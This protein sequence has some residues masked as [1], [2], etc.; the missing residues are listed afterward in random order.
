M[1]VRPASW[2]LLDTS[3]LIAPPPRL[4]S[5]ARS[6]AVSTI[7]LAELAFGLH[8]P[9]PVVNAARE[10]RYRR[11]V[12]SVEP[13]AYSSSAARLYG[14]LC[15]AVH[16]DGR[17]PRPRRL[18]L[19]IASVA[20]AES[21]PL[22]KRSPDDLARDPPIGP[23]TWRVTRRRPSGS[24]RAWVCGGHRR[25]RHDLVGGLDERDDVLCGQPGTVGQRGGDTAGP[26]L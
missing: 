15:A 22:L 20:A 6:V 18:D 1:A 14:A 26:L 17:N 21:I 7:S 2:A 16:D 23:G 19:L 12:E 24:R 25:G 13:L 8:T 9:D 11:I 3:V 10:A 5:Y 4:A